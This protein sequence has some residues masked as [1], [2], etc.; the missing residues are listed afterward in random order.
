[1]PRATLNRRRLLFAAIAVVVAVVVAIL[2]P[3]LIV[4]AIFVG[5]FLLISAL[6]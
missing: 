4:L 6:T 2:I 5:P 1:M 3:I